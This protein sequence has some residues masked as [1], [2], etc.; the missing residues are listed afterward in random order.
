[1]KRGEPKVGQVLE[2]QHCTG[3][4][5]CKMHSD[6]LQSWISM[7]CKSGPDYLALLLNAGPEVLFALRRMKFEAKPNSISSFKRNILEGNSD[8]R[9]MILYPENATSWRYPNI[10]VSDYIIAFSGFG[11]SLK[12]WDWC[13][14]I[15]DKQGKEKQP[16]RH[17]PTSEFEG[18]FAHFGERPNYYYPI[19]GKSEPE[20]TDLRPTGT[21]SLRP[22]YLDEIL[23]CVLDQIIFATL[24]CRE[25]TK[26]FCDW[27]RIKP[28]E[29]LVLRSRSTLSLGDIPASWLGLELQVCPNVGHERVE[30]TIRQYKVEDGIDTRQ[31]FIP[32][33]YQEETTE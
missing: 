19:F 3:M 30:L 32:T 21:T 6:S 17:I 18:P 27:F 14:L 13:D 2:F 1:M 15:A 24:S 8:V 26:H 16:I 4:A 5:A 25:V 12:P 22:A 7:P 10:S 31:L 28:F 11:Y 23:E 20:K 33:V 29:R 9:D